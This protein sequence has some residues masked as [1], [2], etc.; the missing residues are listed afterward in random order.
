MRKISSEI[1]IAAPAAR[2]WDIISDF[3]AYPLWNT[4][5][6]RITLSND[7]F[8]VGAEFDLDCRMSDRL[9]LRNEHEVIL[10]KDTDNYRF[11]MG[12]SR[13]K[14]RPGI[15][16]FRWQSC[17]P[18]EDGCTR[19]INYEQF[20]GPLA[21]LVYLMYSKRLKKA[22]NRYCAALKQYAESPA[23]CHTRR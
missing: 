15:R 11:C 6:P 14:G 2:V 16:S 18:M 23:E 12:T 4:F 13:T 9:Y 7:R 21:P 8:S 17:E 5:T 20:R 19:F 1:I 10:T 22:F 3:D